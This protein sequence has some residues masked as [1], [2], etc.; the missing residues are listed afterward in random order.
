MR[1]V[2][3][4]A[5]AAGLDRA[6]E[7]RGIAMSWLME[8]AGDALARATVDEAGGVYGRRAVVVCGKGN[9]GGDGLVAARLLDTWGMR[10]SV[11]L[12]EGPEAFAGPVAGNLARL[13][14]TAARVRALDALPRELDRADVA[15]DA[16]FGTGFHGVADGVAAEAIIA[17]NEAATPVV[18]ADIPSGVD[19]ATGAVDGPA[20]LADVTVTF[21]VLKPGVVFF[22]GAA[23]S[24]AIEVADI[25]FPDDLIDGGLAVTE[26]SDVARL[27]PVRAPDTN[28]RGTGVVLVVGGSRTMTGAPGLVATA[29]Y[30][31]GAGLVTVAVPESVLPVV[32]TAVPEATFIALP[33]TEEGAIAAEAF[34]LLWDR[35]GDFD[36][37]AIG[38]GLGRNEETAEFARSLAAAVP[39]ALVLD[40]DGLNAFAGRPEELTDRG[41]PEL[42]LTPH[43]GEFARLAGGTPEDAVRDRVA[44]VRS[45]AG[46][47]QATV[48]LKGSRTAIGAPGMA[49]TGL[50]DAVHADPV[51][52]N[53]TGGPALATAG[54]GD[55]LTGTI[56]AMLSRGLTAFDA[57][58]AGAFVHGLAGLIAGQELGEGTTAGDVCDQLPRAI[59]GVGA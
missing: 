39:Q 33:E 40:A 59:R 31:A 21:G 14:H 50:D 46:R 27:L 51:R 15:I 53:V 4:P 35:L 11:V 32:E 45:L 56:A 24:G 57:A 43:A 23:C 41:A 52:I 5:E 37:F 54:S 10:V 49:E 17:M 38:P 58:T 12:L 55:V 20:V 29:A 30:R 26:S 6:C 1:P 28:K 7:D 9:N 16:I 47:T 19:G 3:S 2:L 25:G 36:A 44:S 42:V 13:T 18:A 48:L 34:K 8:N 22:P